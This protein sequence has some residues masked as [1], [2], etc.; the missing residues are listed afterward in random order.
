MEY[1]GMAA[2]IWFALGL[3]GWVIVTAREGFRGPV[4]FEVL[5]ILFTLALGP[6]A[7]WWC[8]SSF[9]PPAH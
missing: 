4:R 6:F 2:L 5:F 8:F 1:V 7:I 9:L 3:V